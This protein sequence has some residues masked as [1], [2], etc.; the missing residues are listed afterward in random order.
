MSGAK[1][2]ARDAVENV[3]RPPPPESRGP[4]ERWLA[5]HPD[6]HERVIASLH[7]LPTRFESPLVIE[8]VAVTDL[9]TMNA[10]LGAAIEASVVDSLNDLRSMWD[11]ES[12]Y[13]GYVFV[14]QAQTF[15]DVLLRSTDPASP[16]P[17]LM[18]IELKGWFAI[19]KEK[20]PSFRYYASVNACASADLL[21]VVPWVF[22]SIVSGKP[23][24]LQPIIT[25]ARFAAEMR[26]YYW[27]HGRQAR[28]LGNRGV[29]VA[30]HIGTYPNKSDKYSDRAI[31]D[32]GGNFGR[33]ARYG[34]MN[35]EVQAVLEQRALGI[36]LSVWQQFLSIFSEKASSDVASQKVE[37]IKKKIVGPATITQNEQAE[38]IRLIAS[39][40]EVLRGKFGEPTESD[41]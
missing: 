7:A 40:L 3:P 35:S 18:G 28:G 5:R 17:V 27:E 31:N 26:N 33:I 12:D 20:E 14:R 38:A 36:P 19:A 29:V 22:D 16:E 24:L 23:K 6:L 1:N 41:T 9:F 11:P 32:N 39:A 2:D 10:P 25:S 13:A 30:D 34:V 21:V 37:K 8:G 4:D 15:P